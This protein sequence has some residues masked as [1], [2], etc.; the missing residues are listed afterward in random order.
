MCEIAITLKTNQVTEPSLHKLSPEDFE[1]VK[2]EKVGSL[3]LSVYPTDAKAYKA[4]EPISFQVDSECD[5]QEWIA[6]ISG[7]DFFKV[8]FGQLDQ[9]I[10]L[11]TKTTLE[12]RP[13]FVTD[14][15]EVIE[16]MGGQ[17]G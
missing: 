12:L 11:D 7:K 3:G 1:E 8:R 13:G 10:H 16:M 9:T 4:K 14:D 17:D 15:L 6:L 5:V 2:P